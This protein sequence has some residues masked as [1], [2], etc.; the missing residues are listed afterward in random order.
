MKR[1]DFFAA[2]GGGIAVLLVDDAAAQQAGRS[3]GNRPQMPQDVGAWLHIGEDGV[4]TAYTGKVDVGQNSRASLTA[5]V[6]E[7]LRVPV[8]SVRFVMGDTDL[9]PFDGGTSGSQSTPMM[10]PQI[11]RAAATAREML[12][13]LAARKW[14]ADRASSSI[15]N[16][17]AASGSHSAG[18]R[19][20]RRSK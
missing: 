15:A 3:G 1:R 5:A 11:R 12:L 16:G 13:D 4:V 20:C 2:F 10:W 14:N 8:A 19:G 6:A 9:T 17:K 7:E 18:T